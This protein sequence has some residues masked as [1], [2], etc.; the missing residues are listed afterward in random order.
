MCFEQIFPLTES[1]AFEVQIIQ[2]LLQWLFFEC[3]VQ[4]QICPFGFVLPLIFLCMLRNSVVFWHCLVI[5]TLDLNLTIT[6]CQ[7]TSS[8][9]LVYAKHS[10]TDPSN[11]EAEPL[12]IL[13]ST[14][15]C[16]LSSE[17]PVFYLNPVE[18]EQLLMEKLDESQGM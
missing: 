2:W 4:I 15:L 16:L 17:F 7:L 5:F 11:K 10:F 18:N 6:C 1:A 9:S 12:L 3:C 13:R 14:S 8:V